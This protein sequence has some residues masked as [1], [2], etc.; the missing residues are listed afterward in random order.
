MAETEIFIGDPSLKSPI[1]I[2]SIPTD[3]TVFSLSS[4]TLAATSQLNIIWTTTAARPQLS[5]WNF[6]MTMRFGV[7]DSDHDWPNGSGL[8]GNQAIVEISMHTDALISDDTQNLR[9]NKIIVKNTSADSFPYWNYFKA[10]T[11]AT[12]VG[13]QS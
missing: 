11:F 2:S 9:R 3:P 8:T 13:V 6:L 4:G 5:L 1:L 10:Y 12:S 7:N